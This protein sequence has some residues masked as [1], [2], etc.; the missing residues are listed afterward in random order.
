MHNICTCGTSAW[1]SHDAHYEL[2]LQEAACL[3]MPG[4]LRAMFAYML[5]FCDVNAPEPLFVRFKGDMCEDFIHQGLPVAEAEALAYY[6][7]SDK[8]HSCSAIS[9]KG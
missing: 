1:S 5:A 9:H 8:L 6:D 3:Q 4:E 7:L 2:C